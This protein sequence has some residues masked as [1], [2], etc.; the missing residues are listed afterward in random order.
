MPSRKMVDDFRRNLK[1][2]LDSLKS[3]L[4]KDINEEKWWG[5][6]VGHGPNNILIAHNFENDFA[7]VEFRMNFDD[8]TIRRL[9]QILEDKTNMLKFYL[10]FRSVISS[11]LTGFELFTDNNNKTLMGFSI[12]MKIFPFHNDLSIRELNRAIQAVVSVGVAGID[13]VAGNLGALG[14]QQELSESPPPPEGMYS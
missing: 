1:E 12:Q 13:Y 3:P 10:G 6:V 7:N 9:S 14:I 5:F 8:E 4:I 11:P 2:S